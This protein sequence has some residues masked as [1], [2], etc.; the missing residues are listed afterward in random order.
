MSQTGSAEEREVEA[1]D[2]VARLA[3][4]LQRHVH[5]VDAEIVAPGAAT[6]TVPAAAA[7]LGVAPGQIIK[8]LLFA[9][10]GGDAAL[11]ILCGDR[12]VDRRRL[13]EASG[14]RQPELAPPEMVLR[15]TGYRVGGTPP[16]GHATPLRV[17]V[18]RAVLDE[19]VVYGGGGTS[20]RMLRIRPDDIV[21]LTG[22]LVAD[23]SRPF[24]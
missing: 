2:A 14:L 23:V 4:Y 3:R 9:S 18:D 20:S 16:V 8:S 24:P 15:L 12:Q 21:R 5:E 22:A 13:A 6:P 10:K 7:A 1:S 11:V 17:V 19:P